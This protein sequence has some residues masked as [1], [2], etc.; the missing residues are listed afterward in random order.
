LAKK[1]ALGYVKSAHL[2][3]KKKLGASAADLPA[4]GGKLVFR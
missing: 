2:S 1:N 4:G 3:L